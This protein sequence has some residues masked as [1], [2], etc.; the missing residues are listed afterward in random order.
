MRLPQASKRFRRPAERVQQAR[1][2]TQERRQRASR[3]LGEKFGGVSQR[4]DA[5]PGGPKV[6][7]RRAG[8]VIP[9][10]RARPSVFTTLERKAWHVARL[11][12]TFGAVRGKEGAPPVGSVSGRSR[13][14]SAAVRPLRL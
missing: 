2:P 10:S 1:T 7:G 4:R 12:R 5:C 13:G 9:R 3:K 8:A 11:L 14:R 6:I